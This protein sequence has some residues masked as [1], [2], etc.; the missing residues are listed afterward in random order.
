[1]V[2]AAIKPA[3]AQTDDSEAVRLARAILEATHTANIGEQVLGQV[4]K[5]VENSLAQANPGR[6]KDIDAVVTESL[7]PEFR[8]SFPALNDKTA[9]I[10]AG[11]FSVE[12]L[13]QLLT[14]YQS[15]LGRKLLQN[16]PEITRQQIALGQKF[17]QDVMSR[18]NDKLMQSIQ[19]HG[20]QRPST[21]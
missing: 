7:V 2:L 4:T 11:I 13:K 14:F 6:Q 16:Q 15:P 18:I 19:A 9:Q 8:K 17:T 1:M 10:Y 3:G 20:L 21:N 12:D 5:L